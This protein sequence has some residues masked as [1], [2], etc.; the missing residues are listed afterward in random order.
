M[1][2]GRYRRPRHRSLSHGVPMFFD[3]LLEARRSGRIGSAEI[4]RSAGQHGHDVLVQD[5]AVSH[6]VHDY[7][8][9]C[10]TITELAIEMHAPI[11]ADDF[12]ILNRCLDEAI[13]SAVTTYS[14]EHQQAHSRN[15]TALENERMG[16]LVHELRNLVNIAV[17]AFGV[18][19]TGNAD[20]GT[21]RGC[22]ESQPHRPPR[23]HRAVAR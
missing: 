2:R 5:L 4:G 9:I 6:V 11:S 15:A 13:T 20:G 18:L 23:S 12:R 8:D 17:V 14:H 1:R 3:Q 22:P 21:D 7:G 10:Q 19:K 16:F